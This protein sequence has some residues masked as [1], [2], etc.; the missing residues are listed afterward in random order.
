MKFVPQSYERNN[1]KGID[2]FTEYLRK[3][4]HSVQDKEEEDYDVDIIS[5][6]IHQAPHKFEIEM[7]H[8]YPFTTRQSFRFPTVSFLA[9]KKKWNIQE[10]FWYVIICGETDYF[11]S[12]HSSVI[13]KPEYLVEKNIRTRERHGF[14]KMYHV[15]KDLCYFSKL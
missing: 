2:K 9:R 7:K 3:R 13:Y 14:D 4:G 15:P 10:G 6:D 1:Q 5:Y 8:G 12:C 11:I